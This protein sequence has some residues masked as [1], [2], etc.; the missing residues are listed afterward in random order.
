MSQKWSEQT[1]HDRKKSER[2]AN[3]Q[4]RNAR[5]VRAPH[6]KTAQKSQTRTRRKASKDT[7][8]TRN[9]RNKGNTGNY[10]DSRHNPD[11]HTWDC[12]PR[13]WEELA[14][15]PHNRHRQAVL[16]GLLG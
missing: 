7:R 14:A 15:V 1:G 11:K 6:R 5:N 3:D 4:Q 13:K 2:N 16:V 12:S 10:K 8:N 9:T